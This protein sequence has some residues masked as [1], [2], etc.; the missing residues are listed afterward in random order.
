MDRATFARLAA[1]HTAIPVTRVLA[2]DLDLETPLTAFWKLQ[3][4]PWNFLL[5]SVEG[6]ERWARYTAMGTEPWAVATV[7]GD[8]L[9]VQER[10]GSVHERR[11]DAPL[12]DVLALLDLG[13]VYR[14]PE[15]LRFG[16]GLVGAVSYDAVRGMEKIPDRH[17]PD[18]HSPDLCFLCTRLMLVW[19]NLTHEATLVFLARTPS[20]VD[21]GAIFREAQE[22]LDEAQA[23]LEGPLP[24]WPR[25]EIP[26]AALDLESAPK[27]ESSMSDDQFAERVVQ[28]K[29]LIQAGDVI[30]VVLSRRFEQPDGGLHPFLVYGALRQLNPSP[31]M[32]YL[33]L[34]DT[35]LVGASPEVLV[36]KTGDRIETRPIAG[37]RPRGEDGAQDAILEKELRADPKECA[38]HL[39]LVDL[40][41]N[42]LGRVAR[43]GSVELETW[44]DVERF[45]HVMHLVSHVAG[46]LE[47]GRSC[48]DVIR[49]VFPAGTLSGAPKVRA[50]EV[51]ESMETGRRGYY[52][53]AV[54]MVG[55]DGDLDL[56]ITI[57]TLVARRGR[58]EVQ[59]GAGI[60][61]D[62][63]PWTEAQETRSKAMGVLR[64]IEEARIRFRGE[65]S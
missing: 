39:M 7:R 59:A 63:D 45:S 8:R 1:E 14:P 9:T 28:A 51:I 36:R 2:R 52:G 4:G 34:G 33:H 64:A 50:M 57:R 16:G 17:G 37:T 30:Q 22:A 29:E 23:R 47:P 21:A 54:G 12:D 26:G 6:G 58:F 35:C 61:W 55:I 11:T 27:W 18:D 25:A 15:G 13:G 3:R 62:S 43:V 48:G 44:M 10:D 40:A 65:G 38:E 56:C 20:G 41:R 46:S 49:A 31:Y 19:D 53:G 60:V 32:F 5:E 42:D 24:A